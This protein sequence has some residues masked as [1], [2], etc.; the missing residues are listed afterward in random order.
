MIGYVAVCD[1]SEPSKPKWTRLCTNLHLVQGQWKCG[2]PAEHSLS[3]ARVSGQKYDRW[4]LLPLGTSRGGA[5][6]GPGMATGLRDQGCNR[7]CN[8][9]KRAKARFR[10]R[11]VLRDR[12]LWLQMHNSSW[13]DILRALR[14]W[15]QRCPRFPRGLFCVCLHAFRPENPKLPVSHHTCR[16]VQWAGYRVTLAPIKAQ[17]RHVSS[18]IVSFWPDSTFVLAWSTFGQFHPSSISFQRS[19]WNDSLQ[20]APRIASLYIQGTCFFFDCSMLLCR[21]AC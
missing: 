1:I 18:H 11:G 10:A 2:R 9:T 8:R 5:T 14:S 15:A 19:A 16:S 6:G 4:L 17:R 12:C 20:P 3:K 13:I 21:S 7:A